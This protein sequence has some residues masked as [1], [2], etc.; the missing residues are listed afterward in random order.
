[1]TGA[2]LIVNAD[3]FGRSAAVNE[4]VVRC[5]ERGVVT[6]ATLMVRWPDAEA[7]AAYARRTPSL[8][9]GLHFDVGEWVYADGEWTARYE[10]LAEETPATVREELRRQLERFEQLLGRPP[11]HLDSHQHVHR[12]DP[13]RGAVLEAAERLGIPVR[14]ERGFTYDGGF[15]GQ[16]HHAEPMPELVS[17]DALVASI[18]ALPDGVTEFGCHPAT[19]VD[20]ETAYAS[21]RL[22]EARTLCDPRVRAAVDRRGARLASFG[23]AAALVRSDG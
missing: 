15:F 11:D 21:E 14:G 18:E 22:I 6:S 1:M 10:V 16:G 17:V 7:A 23:D 4:G 20:H 3:D 12:S 2:V 5:H 9:V 13:A 8:G 19:A